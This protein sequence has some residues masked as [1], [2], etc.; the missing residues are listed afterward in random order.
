MVFVPK[1]A[2]EGRLS[3][4]LPQHGELAKCQSLT[5][6]GVGVGDCKTFAP[7]A[8][9]RRRDRP[10]KMVRVIKARRVTVIRTSPGAV[11]L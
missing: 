6:F 10:A 2:G 1:R 4:L 11:N 5:P 7:Q 9:L 8:G 3:R